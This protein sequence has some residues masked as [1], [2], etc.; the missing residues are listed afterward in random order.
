MQACFLMVMAGC[1]GAL[2]HFQ[3]THKQLQLETYLEAV[4]QVVANG[5]SSLLLCTASLAS[6]LPTVL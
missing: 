1:I 4:G 6:A 2:T 5:D 3:G